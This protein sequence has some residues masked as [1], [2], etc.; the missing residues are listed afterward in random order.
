MKQLD[1]AVIDAFER[2][3][4]PYKLPTGLRAN[5]LQSGE[6]LAE[7]TEL[8][9][10][11]NYILLG[12]RAQFEVE[13]S[14]EFAQYIASS[15]WRDSDN[16]NEVLIRHDAAG[17]HS[18]YPN[19]LEFML[20]ELSDTYDTQAQEFRHPLLRELAQEFNNYQPDV[21]LVLNMDCGGWEGIMLAGSD[22]GERI[23]G[24]YGDLK[25]IQH[26]GQD[27]TYYRYIRKGRVHQ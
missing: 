17:M 5:L 9:S 12:N 21:S 15:Y 10:I 2:S 7:L 14:E 3:V 4:F 18:Q 26:D 16:F 23:L 27:Y 20:T 22:V 8:R 13:F 1:T 6:Q 25:V 24:T 11:I 19:L